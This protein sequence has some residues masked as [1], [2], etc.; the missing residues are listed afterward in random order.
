MIGQT[1]NN[2]SNLASHIL[3]M[4]LPLVINTKNTIIFNLN[5]ENKQTEQGSKFINAAFSGFRT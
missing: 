4:C 3:Q 5:M 2:F 1:N